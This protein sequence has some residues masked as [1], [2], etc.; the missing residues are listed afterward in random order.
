V[1]FWALIDFSLHQEKT[2]GIFDWEIRGKVRRGN[3]WSPLATGGARQVI[4]VSRENSINQWWEEGKVVGN[5]DDNT[6]F[7]GIFQWK[8]HLFS[9]FLSLFTATTHARPSGKTRE[10]RQLP[11]LYLME[12]SSRRRSIRAWKLCLARRHNL[13]H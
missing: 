11:R 8:A 12:I 6:R 1:M 2:K 9:M 3:V 5:Y 13:A 4:K 10:F 7:D